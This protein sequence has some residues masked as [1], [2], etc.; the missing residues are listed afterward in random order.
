MTRFEIASFP[1]LTTRRLVL[2]EVVDADAD[3]LLA[4]R[5]DPEVQRYNLKPM[6][7]RSEA[8]SLVRTMQGWYASRYATQWGITLRGEDRVLGLCG[9]HD[10]SQ[11]H[12]R[13]S[14]GYDLARSHW[15]RGIAT[16]AMHAVLRFGFERMNLNR[17]EA[18]TIVDNT[19]SIRLLERLGFALEGVRRESSLEDGGR[20]HGSAVYGLLRS[21][22]L[23]EHAPAES[24]TAESGP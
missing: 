8:L 22:Y 21:E 1:T 15:G 19:R 2:R 24:L 16:E 4:F 9:L 23:P 17:V 11:T 14:L 18:V 3:D 5:G 13:A 10:W 7:T 20:F 12:R 6:K